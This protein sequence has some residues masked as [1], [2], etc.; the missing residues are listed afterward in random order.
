MKMM[1][2]FFVLLLALA[3]V[4]CQSA[5]T[6]GPQSMNS[7]AAGPQVGM[8]PRALNDLTHLDEHGGG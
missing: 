8:D 4:G 1:L 6:L 3:V 2:R 5:N 7:P